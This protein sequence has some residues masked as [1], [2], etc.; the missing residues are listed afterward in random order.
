MQYW[1]IQCLRREGS[2]L[3]HLSLWND[4]FLYKTNHFLKT[5]G[6][7]SKVE[8]WVLL[9]SLTGC[10]ML[11]ELRK[12]PELYVSHSEK[13]W[14]FN[15]ILYLKILYGMLD[16]TLGIFI[17]FPLYIW[18]LKI[19]F[20]GKVLNLIWFEIWYPFTVFCCCCFS[21]KKVFLCLT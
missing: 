10:V 1:S 20:G 21:Y 9:L 5:S 16:C 15:E 3:S 14:W 13:E 6:L 11:D 7:A 4:N 19:T 2:D 12:L 18:K 8:L 17:L